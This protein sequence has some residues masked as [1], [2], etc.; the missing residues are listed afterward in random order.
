MCKNIKSK[1]TTLE[2]ISNFFGC[3]VGVRQ[4]E[5]LS[6]FLFSIFLNDLE[7][8]LNS[9]GVSG[10][11]INVTTDDIHIFLK[12]LLLLY[13]AETVIFSDDK[14]TL[15]Y[16]LNVFEDYCNEWHLTVNIQKTK[17]VILVGDEQIK[18]IGLH[19]KIKQ[20]KLS[21]N[22]NTWEYFCVEVDLTFQQK[23][24]KKKK[25]YT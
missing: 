2:G 20:L 10:V 5:N 24:K 8:S 22:I 7:A 19:I 16:A 6:P 11:N 14:D 3:N 9:K 25:K 17:T 13:A 23:K 21:T 12:L 1:V 4:G 15:Q 18:G